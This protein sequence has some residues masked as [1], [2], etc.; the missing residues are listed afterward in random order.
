[1]FREKNFPYNLYKYSSAEYRFISRIVA[2]RSWKI[3][4]INVTRTDCSTF[5]DKNEKKTR[6]FPPFF[7]PFPPLPLPLPT[8]L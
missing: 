8:L 4:A 2:S 1:M 5:N 3:F 6:P 7:S